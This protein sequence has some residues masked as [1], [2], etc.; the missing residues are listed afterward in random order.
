VSGGLTVLLQVHSYFSFGYGVSSPGTL[1]KRAAEL[2][3]T[4]LA[5]L[6]FGGVYGAV[7]LA[8]ACLE[9]GMGALYG[10]S[11]NVEH[12]GETHPLSLLAPTR[13]AYARLNT[14]LTEANDLGKVTLDRLSQ[15]MDL[16]VLSGGPR[17]RATQLLEAGK[18]G[19]LKEWLELLSF[20]FGS[21]F[22]VQLSH[23]LRR[24]DSQRA[25]TLHKVALELGLKAV[26]APEVRYALEEHYPLCDALTCGRLGLSVEEPHPLRPVNASGAIHAPAHYLERLPFPDA[27]QNALELAQRCTFDLLPERLIPARASVPEHLSPKRYL[28]E[29]CHLALKKRYPLEQQEAA[30]ARLSHELAIVHQMGLEHFF[31]LAAEVCDECRSRGVLY[32]GRGSAAGSVLC[33]LLGI[34]KIDPLEHNLLFERFLHTGRKSM[35]DVDIDL[36]SARRREIIAWALERYGSTGGAAMVCNR[37]TYL[38]S[39]ALQDLGRALGLPQFQVVKLTKSLGR[40]FR[41][42][43]PHRVREAAPVFDEVLGD[44]P[45]K[46]L[47]YRLLEK[48]ERG[49]VRNIAPHSGGTVLSKEP[50]SHYSA[51]ETSS[52]SIRLIGFDKD[53]A[54][55]L[56]LIKLDLLG[57]RMLSALENALEEIERHF[58]VR[59]EPPTFPDH[60]RVWAKLAQGD[61]MGLFQVE[62]PA[63]VQNIIR[64]RPK[65]LLELAHQ[66][67]L[68]RPGPLQNGSVHPYV[69]RKQ[70]LEEIEYDHPALEP[71]LKDTLGVLLFQEQILRVCVH[72][73]G[74]TW[75][76]AEKYRKKLTS[77][78]E[79]F[80]L[81]ALKFAFVEGGMRHSGAML[82]QAE[83]IFSKLSAFGGGYGFAESHAHA[84]AQ[85]TY[86]SAYLREFYPAPFFTGF[87]NHDPGMHSRQTLA[88]EI[89]KRG[90]PILPLCI[91]ASSA[92]FRVELSKKEEKRSSVAPSTSPARGQGQAIRFGLSGVK[93]LSQGTPQTIAL[94][95][96]HG[97]F[98]GVRD[99]YLRV[100]LKR[101]E[102]LA[103]VQAGAFDAL[104]TRREALFALSALEHAVKGGSQALFAPVS[105]VPTLPALS[106][107]EILQLDLEHKGMSESGRHPMDLQRYRMEALGCVPLETL[108][109]G[110][111]VRTA[112]LVIQKQRPPTAHGYAFFVLE[113]R[114]TRVQAVISPQLWD[115][116]RTLLRDASV[117]MVE[118]EVTRKGAHI[119][120]KVSK[121]W[122]FESARAPTA[123]LSSVR[124]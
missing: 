24:E 30:L 3:F 13:A 71:I 64:T 18:W 40:D 14:V 95:R 20:G 102:Y 116:H 17:S 104:S 45:V 77:S 53:D 73:A 10:A 59:L 100:Q 28:K 54:E 67:A 83:V 35:P 114:A 50:L 9:H 43:R 124:V 99:F 25:S 89:L 41:G 12:G 65:N 94:E 23:G 34:T 1:A 42:L 72:F 38:L 80:E 58:G 88:Q 55:T 63:Q 105:S 68:I 74:L 49:T 112:G 15:E 51:L 93:G 32:A 8:S 27:V 36:S 61:T 21:D 66:V 75:S 46:E 117:L 57:L 115:A 119:G 47:L 101:D 56:G 86:S 62:S 5:L 52:G 19:E 118:G 85:H 79:A 97:E 29:R 76:E 92:E 87:L 91:N 113:D 96:L 98:K 122:S 11:L 84:F 39:S 121:L 60:P 31:L 103:L 4:H 120:I 33:F 82:E 78:E 110:Q 70:G 108:K 37:T 7:E 111:T 90:I 16:V 44:A 107:A 69:R 22:Y 109:G 26:A 6:D 123:E 48:M 2:G 106:D 81:D